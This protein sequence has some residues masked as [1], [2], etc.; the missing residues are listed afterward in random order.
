V[1]DPDDPAATAFTV[2]TTITPQTAGT[3]TLDTPTAQVDLEPTFRS[4]VF[5]YQAGTEPW[6]LFNMTTVGSVGDLGLEMLDPNVTAGGTPGFA[7]GRLDKLAIT[8]TL[9][10]NSVRPADSVPLFGGNLDAAG[11]TPIP[12]ILKNPAAGVPP[13]T[14]SF[15]V[16]LAPGFGSAGTG[17]FSLDFSTRIYEDFAGPTLAAGDSKTVGSSIAGAGAQQRF[18]FE[19][20]PGNQVAI[21]VTPTGAATL[22]SVVE[23]LNADETVAATIDTPGA[24]S[25]DTTSFV[26]GGGGF[27][28][29]RVR[30]A[31]ATTGTFDVKVDVT[32]SGYTF[33]VGPATFTNACV[34]GSP[35]PLA[36]DGSGLNVPTDEGLSAPI[37]PPTGFTLFGTAVG[38]LRVSSNGFLTFNLAI[39][40]AKFDHGLLAGTPDVAIAPYWADL[41]NVQVCQRTGNTTL[42]IQWTGDDLNTGASVQFQATLDSTDNLIQFVY[43]P[44]HAANGS[45]ASVGLS[46]LSAG[47]SGVFQIGRDQPILS[48]STAFTIEPN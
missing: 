39:A 42:T 43:G 23:L 15:L 24:G 4:N 40:D 9:N 31:G 14:T 30:G 29:F 10:G 28:A 13:A 21:H 17:T 35:V 45:T 18:Y 26:M 6:Q 12:H 48:R 20:E 32:A 11:N 41:E 33:A 7:F 37:T 2:T 1:L 25:V 44:A 46:D 3:I 19:T 5:T 22:D 47:G 36:D 38:N 34:H 16:H 8:D 27:T